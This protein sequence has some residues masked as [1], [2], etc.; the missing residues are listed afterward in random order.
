MTE[1]PA[2]NDDEP[3]IVLRLRAYA[4]GMDDVDPEVI[5][6]VMREAAAEI[7]E[8]RRVIRLSRVRLETVEPAGR[9]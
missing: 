3:D 2:C 9:A 6:A 1:P 5:E 7:E 4:L 8:L